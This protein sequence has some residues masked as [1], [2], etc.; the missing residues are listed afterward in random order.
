RRAPPFVGVDVER[1]VDRLLQRDEK[2]HGERV[3]SVVVA[4]ERFEIGG[5]AAGGAARVL[6]EDRELAQDELFVGHVPPITRAEN[7]RIASSRS[8]PV[9]SCSMAA[10]AT[11]RARS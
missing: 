10:R 3:L 11:K 9:S 2:T 7:R 8:S 5:P 4:F 1:D 6:A